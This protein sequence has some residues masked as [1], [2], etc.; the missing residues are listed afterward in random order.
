MMSGLNVKIDVL[1][2][3]FLYNFLLVHDK[4]MWCFALSLRYMT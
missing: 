2:F 4:V 3:E 1:D